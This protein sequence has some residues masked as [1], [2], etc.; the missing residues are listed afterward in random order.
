M[1]AVE[2]AIRLVESSEADHYVGVGG[3]PPRRHLRHG[4]ASTTAGATYSVIAAGDENVR[5]Q[6]RAQL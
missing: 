1:D 4:G 5:I 3:R 2:A 6:G